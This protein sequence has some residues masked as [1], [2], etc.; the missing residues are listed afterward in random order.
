MGHRASY[1]L[2]ED[3]TTQIYYSHWGAHRAPEH[4]LAGP[5]HTMAFLRT[6]KPATELLDT[7]WAEGGILLDADR[8]RLLFWGGEDISFCPYL[9]RVF[10]PVLGHLWPGWSVEWAT[11]GIV[12]FARYLGIAL[13]DV[14]AG[15]VF[16]RIPA[17]LTVRWEDGRIADY[18]FDIP[19]DDQ[20]GDILEAG[21]SGLDILRD[22]GSSAVPNE[23]DYPCEEGAYVDMKAKEIWI[24]QWRTL[25]PRYLWALE[26]Y[27]P[28]WRI[29]G[30]V[31][32]I[33]RQVQLSGRDPSSV[34]MPEDKAIE[35]LIEVLTLSDHAPDPVSMLSSF[36][37]GT[38]RQIHPD[39]FTIDQPPPSQEERRQILRQFFQSTPYTGKQADSTL[40][41]EEDC[42]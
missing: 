40:K 41:R 32:G 21:P 27:W 12:D 18:L 29:E 7:T 8:R 37:P 16:H 10:L 11:Q 26:D 22:K 1:V 2:I 25:D 34:A 14:L 36:P 39:F 31:D 42:P 28:G 4:L 5:K 35:E 24:W 3:G 13:E 6:L 38:I 17:L 19:M 15:D 23:G 20:M 33:V 30:H 9:R